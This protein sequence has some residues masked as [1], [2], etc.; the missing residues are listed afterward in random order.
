MTERDGRR[1]RPVLKREAARREVAVWR[2]AKLPLSDWSEQ[3][4]ATG[5][6]RYGLFTTSS[7]GHRSSRTVE[8]KEQKEL[9]RTTFAAQRRPLKATAAPTKPPS[10]EYHHRRE[11]LKRPTGAAGLDGLPCLPE[12]YHAQDATCSQDHQGFERDDRRP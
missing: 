4:Q 11:C 2:N 8:S 5:K 7:E 3:T 6:A 10:F 9:W 1:L 12:F